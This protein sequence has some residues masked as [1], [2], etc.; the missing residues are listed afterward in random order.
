M[1]GLPYQ[2][3]AE[4]G[5]DTLEAKLRA[6]THGSTRGTADEQPL[7]EYFGDAEYRDLQQLAEQAHMLRSRAP[8]LGNVVLLPG[9]MGSQLTTVDSAGDEDLIWVH[10]G[11]LALGRIERLQLTPDG[12]GETNPAFQVKAT[13][14]DKRTYTRA[15]LWL[16][17]RWHV[18]AFAYDWR[19]DIDYAA[20]A[21]AKFIGDTFGEQPVHLV[22]HSM[23]GLVARNFIRR[24]R[25]LWGR[26]RQNDP[27]RGGRLIM[28]GTPNFGSFAIP[29]ALTGV[30]PLVRLLAAADVEHNLTELLAI[31]NTFVGT[32]QL[33]PA[34][35]KIPVP[36]QAIYRQQSWG[37]FFVLQKHLERAL[38][39]H[40]ELEKAETIDPERMIYIA[41][42]GQ[43]TVAGLRIVAPGEF[44]YALT[45]DGD[46]RVPH[47]LGLLPDVPTYYVNA[48]HGDLVRDEGVLMALDELLAHGCTTSLAKSPP[49]AR[50]IQVDGMLWRRSMDEP[51]IS[52]AL[53]DIAQRAK[54]DQASPD[55]VRMAEESLMRAGLGQAQATKPLARVDKRTRRS[56]VPER[57][58][59]RVEVV[60]G[61]ITRVEAPVVVVGHYKGIPPVRAEGAI[62]EA[63]A[64]WIS[65][66]A[67]RGMIGADLGELFFVPVLNQQIA[68]KAVL[69]AG[70]GE[71]GQFSRNDLRY[72][73]T[74]VAYAVAALGLDRFAS[75]LIGS[76]EGNLPKEGALRAMLRGVG[77]ALMRLN[78]RER[79]QQVILIERDETYFA[80]MA[81]IVQRL[82]QD[83]PIPELQIELSLR[84]LPAQKHSRRHTKERPVD[85]PATPLPGTRIT[86][87][88]DRDVFRFS[89][90]SETAVI[91]VRE[92]AVQ[93]HFATGATERLMRSHTREDQEKYGQLLHTYLIPED[94]RRVIDDEKPLTLIL[95][96]STAAFPWEMAGFRGT[97][98]PVFF[99]PHLRLTRQ[100]RTLLSAA[101]GVAPPLNDRLKVLVIAD[102][103]HEPELQLPGARQEGREVVK[104]LHRFK[105]RGD[106][107]L[108][109]VERIGPL[110]CDPVEILALLLTDDFDIV[111]FA[112][113]GSF[114]ENDPARSGWVFGKDCT[115]SALEIF[116]ARRVPRLVFANACFSAV[117]TA[118]QALTAAE[119]NRQL[120]G[121]AQ[122]F[123]ERGVLNYIGTGWPVEDAPASTFAGVFY[124]S[125][126][127]GD[128][129]GAALAAARQEILHDG[130][131]WGAYQHYGQVEDRLVHRCR[132]MADTDMTHEAVLAATGRAQS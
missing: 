25:A 36:T 44:D 11:R 92:V 99:G 59:L 84:K 31:L 43:E 5:W 27:S 23:G 124:E 106:L 54:H 112:G 127:Q 119:M 62:D 53:E 71:P 93:S 47:A 49:R 67:A 109:I 41:G 73:S 26:M 123:F 13:S 90:L 113:H 72:L 52:H 61:D 24:H 125:I 101:P 64:F 28:L 116:R 34:P 89:A 8:A 81:D 103:A 56:K 16:R 86:V 9:I 105:R 88:R 37:P 104:V 45:Y 96:R 83:N 102:P 122:A 95:D 58:P 130:S 70:M 108:E 48:A 63:L 114:D 19:Q 17:T 20:D 128:T 117:V 79:L 1:V 50:T 66:I 30:E 121:L 15:M 100:F 35:S 76:G 65:R 38:Q 51:H 18:E 87:E 69:L 115:L 74:N 78:T 3:I 21:L 4:M 91:P 2:D 55:E 40:S 7:A 60:L 32:Y 110:E 82:A 129:L 14:I 126:L 10:L 6:S 42:S 22:A 111:H 75:V 118:G 120:A 97:R 107:K 46:G 39:F 131:T 85:L 80:E 98:G 68:A 94:F 132:N 29:Q 57:V 77:D 12:A 33:L